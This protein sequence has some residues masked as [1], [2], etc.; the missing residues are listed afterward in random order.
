[1]KH[2]LL[3]FLFFSGIAGIATG[4]S[5]STLYWCPGGLA[6]E[7]LQTTPGPGCEPLVEKWIEPDRLTVRPLV[8]LSTSASIVAM[9]MAHYRQFLGC[10]AT[11]PA[12]LDRLVDLEQEAAGILQQEQA[13]LPF[14]SVRT[15][16]G[17]GLLLPVVRARH[18]LRELKQRLEQVAEIRA[19]LPTLDF[20]SAGREHRRMEELFGSIERDFPQPREPVRAPTGP[21]I[22]AP[23]PGGRLGME[24]GI[25]PPF[26]PTIGVTPPTGQEI[27]TTPPTGE[28][29]GT[30]P[31]TGP[32]IGITPPTG[33]EIGESKPK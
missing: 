7:R 27:G 28:E 11:D 5:P 17:K 12:S 22:G 18:E 16:Q 10:C 25:Q 32:A 23:G 19:T 6:Q 4:L 8:T 2:S 9:F 15:G 20:E 29:I 21:E 24:I 14:L 31:P 3:A 1:M 33:P 30:T 26:G 13:I